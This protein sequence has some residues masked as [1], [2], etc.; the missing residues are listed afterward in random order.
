MK[1]GTSGLQSAFAASADKLKRKGIFYPENYSTEA[2]KKLGITSGNFDEY[3]TYDSWIERIFQLARD[4]NNYH[5]I[6]LSSEFMIQMLPKIYSDYSSLKKLVNIVVI[7]GFRCP[8][9]ILPSK[10]GQDVKRNG[11]ILTF[12]HYLQANSYTLPDIK[13]MALAAATLQALN[14]PTISFNYSTIRNNL[15][16]YIFKKLDC[17]KEL[18]ESF[19]TYSSVNRSLTLA[20]LQYCLALN[21][22][23]NVRTTQ[24]LTDALI[25]KYPTSVPARLGYSREEEK[26][27]V[28][29]NRE[30]I[31]V[32]NGFLDDINQIKMTLNSNQRKDDKLSDF[33]QFLPFRDLI[34]QHL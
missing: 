8:F 24:K 29:A 23:G 1:T 19:Q 26:K 25:A 7:V 5:T 28:N 10:Y 27:I 21:T 16:Q 2:A 4:K 22:I 6:L 9:E 3:K 17:E 32:I 34:R 15:V 20:E 13:H 14:I 12:E 31:Q 30:Y 33:T 18:E 11:C